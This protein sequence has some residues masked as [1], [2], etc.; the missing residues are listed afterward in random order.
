M[1]LATESN[2]ARKKSLE[3]IAITRILFGSLFPAFANSFHG[4]LVC[5]L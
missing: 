5:V 2:V 4:Y 3:V 1:L